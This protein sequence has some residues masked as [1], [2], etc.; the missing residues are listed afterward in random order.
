MPRINEGIATRMW[1]WV[2]SPPAVVKGGLHSTARRV[3]CK[4]QAKSRSESGEGCTKKEEF[5]LTR[6][7]EL[8]VEIRKNK[9]SV[10]SESHPRVSFASPF[11]R[12][13]TPTLPLKGSHPGSAQPQNPLKDSKGASPTLLRFNLPAVGRIGPPFGRPGGLKIKAR[14]EVPLGPPPW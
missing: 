6:S 8:R 13:L 11:G 2:G 10:T 7:I 1:S 9:A 5:D 12:C 4:S 3:R 14:A